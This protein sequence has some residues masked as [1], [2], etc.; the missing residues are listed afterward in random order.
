MYDIIISKVKNH[1]KIFFR[2]DMLSA[3]AYHDHCPKCI[4]K[5]HSSFRQR[6]MNVFRFHNVYFLL[7]LSFLKPI[8][9]QS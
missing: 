8:M 7:R 2:L 4:F 9:H 5:V 6:L 1:Y 3:Q